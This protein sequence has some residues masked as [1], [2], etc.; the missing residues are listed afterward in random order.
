MNNFYVAGQNFLI[1]E[2]EIGGKK[3]EVDSLSLD[4][5]FNFNREDLLKHF[6][7]S[8]AR[9]GTLSEIIFSKAEYEE[10]ANK[11]KM[12]FGGDFSYDLEHPELGIN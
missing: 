7:V 10:I 5:G 9:S 1:K 11:L 4:W 2:I 3:K 6:N 8:I 12:I